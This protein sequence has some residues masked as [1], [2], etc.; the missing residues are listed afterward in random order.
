M[1]GGLIFKE[2]WIFSINRLFLFKAV[3]KP[4][5]ARLPAWAGWLFG[6]LRLFR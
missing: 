5:G 2:L 4:I 6:E 1:A 3:N